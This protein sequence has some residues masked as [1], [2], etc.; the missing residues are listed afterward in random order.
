MIYHLTNVRLVKINLSNFAKSIFLI[1]LHVAIIT[2][3]YVNYPPILCH[4]LAKNRI[5]VKMVGPFALLHFRL[6]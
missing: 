1:T 6:V 5:I 2:S 4:Y 3:Y